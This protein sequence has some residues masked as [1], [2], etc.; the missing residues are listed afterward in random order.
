MALMVATFVVAEELGPAYDLSWNTID[1]GGAV[2]VGDINSF[3]LTGTIGQLDAHLPMTGDSFELAGGFWH[4]VELAPF[5]QGDITPSGGDGL[6]NIDD[7]LLLINS[8]GS[9]NPRADID[10]N[11]TV[12][13][14]DLLML[15]IDWGSC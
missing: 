14:D 12:D 3:Q 5:C 2:S 1:N 6:V 10:H 4:G 13:M 8:W 9:N 15:L 11:G 7:L